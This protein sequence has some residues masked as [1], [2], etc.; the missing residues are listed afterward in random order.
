MAVL[1]YGVAM[2][3]F[4]AVVV[5]YLRAA[6]GLDPIGL[7]TAP[8]AESHGT[9]QSIEQARE[10]ATLVMIAAVGWLAGRGTLERLAWAATIFGT[11]DIV[12]YAGLRVVQGWPPSLSTWDVLFLVPVPW[13]GPVAAPLIVSA[14]LVGVG[15]RAARRLRSGRSMPVGPVRALAA[16]GGGLL[17]ISS[18]FVEAGHVPAGEGSSWAGW[19]IFGAGMALA[20]GATVSSFG[21]PLWR[22][23][24][25]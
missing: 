3:Y 7:A 6:L 20:V 15:L 18:F 16:I 24:S 23:V 1:A 21:E 14:A 19:P 13:V 25:G 8:R 22:R 4:E 5:V 12:Y 10:L 17:V 11:W 9:F 2:G